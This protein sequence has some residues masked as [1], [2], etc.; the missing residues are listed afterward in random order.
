MWANC[1]KRQCFS[2]KGTNTI[3]KLWGSGFVNYHICAKQLIWW[4]TSISLGMHRWLGR[5]IKPRAWEQIYGGLE[6][7]ESNFQL[8]GTPNA[9]QCK[10]ILRNLLP[11]SNLLMWWRSMKQGRPGV[12][13]S[14]KDVTGDPIYKSTL[15]WLF[16]FENTYLSLPKYNLRYVRVRSKAETLS[17]EGQ[18]K[19]RS[20]VRIGDDT[21]SSDPN[22]RGLK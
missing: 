22:H 3:I 5:T 15:L 8:F 2:A 10:E 18:D 9:L 14:V 7:K 19:V 11:F 13:R 20:K 6:D 1:Q 4:L 21:P 17:A 12:C 16:V